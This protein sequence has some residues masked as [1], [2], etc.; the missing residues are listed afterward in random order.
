MQRQNHKKPEKK[1]K[2][3]M[4]VIRKYEPVPADNRKSFYG[5]CIVYVYEDGSET[6]FS[7]DTKIITKHTNG[8]YTRHYNDYTRTTG[9]HIIAFCGMNKAQFCALEV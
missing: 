5:K 7:Y 6:L 2:E 1:G 3:L 8:T 9:R 4:K